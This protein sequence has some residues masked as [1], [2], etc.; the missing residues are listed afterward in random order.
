MKNKTAIFLTVCD[1]FDET[2]KSIRSIFKYTENFDLYIYDMASSDKRLFGYY[3]YLII[4][5]SSVTVFRYDQ[6]SLDSYDVYWSKN[7]AWNNFIKKVAPDYKHV[8]MMDNDIAISKNNWLSN[9]IDLLNDDGISIVS[10]YDCSPKYESLHIAGNYVFNVCGYEVY[11]RYNVVSRLWI[12]KSSYFINHDLPSYKLITR[13]KN[14][15]RMPTDWYYWQILKK[16]NKFIAVFKNPYAG[17]VSNKT[18]SKRTE[19][20]IG[21]DSRNQRL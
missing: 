1:R 18:K 17:N 7:Y 13:N 3:R 2:I 20:G 6:I 11:L 9:S 5:N 21:D 12:A 8:V 16:E 10:P 15:D 14:L 4:S 19:K